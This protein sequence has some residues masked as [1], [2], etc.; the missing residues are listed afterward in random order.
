MCEVIIYGDAD[1][2][3]YN[4]GWSPEDKRNALAHLKALESFEFVYFLVT[5]QRSLLYMKEAAVQ[6]QGE[7]QDIVSGYAC[8]EQCCSDLKDLRANVDKYAERIFQ[9]SC[10]LA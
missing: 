10:R 8:I 2:E 1:Y 3:I 6:L 7:K 4:D 9:H 5:L